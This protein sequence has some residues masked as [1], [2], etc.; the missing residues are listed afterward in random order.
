MLAI[1]CAS[2]FAYGM[3]VIHFDSKAAFFL[4]P[5]RAWQLLAGCLVGVC[6]ERIPNHRRARTFLAF[7][8]VGAIIG[9]AACYSDTLIYPGPWALIPTFGAVLVLGCASNTWVG[10]ALSAKL[11]RWVGDRS[12]SIYLWHWPFLAIGS[13][14]WPE[15]T[16]AKSIAI[17]G[18][19]SASCLAFPIEDSIRRARINLPNAL[20]LGTAGLC[21]I[22]FCSVSQ[23]MSGRTLPTENAGR[24]NQIQHA[25]HDFGRNYSDHCHL[26]ADDVTQPPCIYG[27]KTSSKALYLFG[28]SHAAMWFNPIVRAADKLG[29]KLIVRTR[30]SCPSAIVSIWN[31]FLK[32]YYKNCDIWRSAVLREISKAHPELV[33]ISNFGNYYGWLY[34]RPSNHIFAPAEARAAWGSGISSLIDSL[35]IMSHVTVIRDTPTQLKSYKDCLS[36]GDD[37]G[38][39]REAAMSQ[40]EPVDPSFLNYR[41]KLMDLTGRICTKAWCPAVKDGTIIY[42]DDH[43]LTATFTDT[44]ATEFE[45]QLLAVAPQVSAGANTPIETKSR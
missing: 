20:R 37:C 26:T 27:D 3:Y 6:F 1:L 39:G 18:F 8:G 11:L 17:L 5:P 12:Y 14:L 29:W 4:F 41:I 43:H 36:R 25:S 42:Q 45:E 31:P 15:N 34:D 30:S 21:I 22:T 23:L 7:S 2:S 38:R 9:S 35:P 28:D 40:M 10:T 13:E 44:L 19:I 24:A 16:I 33:I 32:A